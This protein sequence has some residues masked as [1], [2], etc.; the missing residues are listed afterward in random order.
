MRTICFFS[1]YF[2]REVLPYYVEIYLLELS[3][4][5]NEIVF[6]TNTKQLSEPSMN[7]LTQHNIKCLLLK[8]EGYDFGM[9]GKAFKQFPIDSYEQVALV[10]DSALLFAPLNKF[11]NWANK[12]NFDYCG[13]TDSYAI[14]YHIQSYFL[15]VN[16][17]AIPYCRDYFQKIGILPNIQQV[18]EKYEVGL[19]TFLLSNGLKLGAF[20]SNNGYKGE[21]SPYY[22]LLESHLKQGAPLVKKKIIY[23]SYRK[24][25]LFTLMRMNFRIEAA[26]FIEMIKKLHPADLIIN[27]EKAQSDLPSQLTSIQ[28]ALYNFKR[29]IFHILKR[30]IKK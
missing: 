14:S 7:F 1:S 25:E 21:F 17:Q 12:A 6:L 16:K 20:L 19:S 5:F 23:A 2:E 11:M 29:I 3:R 28:I 24:D 9:W 10:N 22:F 15:I 26:Y 30:A 18:I 13:M 27:F 4:H 8:N